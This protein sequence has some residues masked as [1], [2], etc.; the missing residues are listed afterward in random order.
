[1][2]SDHL[3]VMPLKSRSDKSRCSDLY[4][5]KEVI[6]VIVFR[7]VPH[8]IQHTQLPINC[9]KFLDDPILLAPPD[10]VQSD[11]SP[12]AFSHFMNILNGSEPQ[13]SPQIADDLMLLG[14]GFGHNDLI[15]TFA[16]R[17]DVSSRREN[18]CDR[19]QELG[20]FDRGATLE[21]DL[22]LMRDSLAVLQRDISTIR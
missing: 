11:A 14:R 21:A 2:N 15:A 5:G 10:V 22:R 8:S 20:R 6:F 7:D 19:L 18:V 9:Q 17:Q 13:F 16:P 1:M 4:K 12:D 3:H